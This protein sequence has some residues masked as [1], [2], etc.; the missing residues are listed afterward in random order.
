MPTIPIDQIVRI[1]PAV[2][3]AAGS[4]IDLNGVILSDSEYLPTGQAVQFALAGDVSDY[5]GPESVEADM[6]TIYFNGYEGA[7]RKPGRIFF[8]RYADADVAAF[9][10]SGS[11]ETMTLSELQALSGEISVVIDGTQETATLLDFSGVTSFS[12][13]AADI[14]TG[15]GVACVFDSQFS[16]FIIT[17]G[18]TGATS[19]IDFATGTLSEDLK[20][21]EQTGAITT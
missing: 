13:A 10:R 9:L 20:L 7:T 21:T 15:L 4:A 5:F 12:E 17:S 2:L 8:Y 1:N 3:E 6:A 14:A 18:T 11:L 16:A 19:T